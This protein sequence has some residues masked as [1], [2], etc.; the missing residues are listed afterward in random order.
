MGGGSCNLNAQRE[1]WRSEAS[2]QMPDHVFNQ[3]NTPAV[4][5][6]YPVKSI[7]RMVWRGRGPNPFWWFS[8]V[9]LE[10]AAYPPP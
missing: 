1:P 6:V 10:S 7:C 3:I 9:G 5:I 4:G 2:L 8:V